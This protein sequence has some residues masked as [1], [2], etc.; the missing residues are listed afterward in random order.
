MY[1]CSSV[2]L[3]ARG[4]FK[5]FIWLREYEIPI[6]IR[7]YGNENKIISCQQTLAIS[8]CVCVRKKK[9]QYPKHCY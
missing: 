5:K 1:D 8:C 2:F 7:N 9:R 3:N 6:V 4:Y